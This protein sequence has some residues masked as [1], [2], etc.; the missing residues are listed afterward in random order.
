VAIDEGW[1]PAYAKAAGTDGPVT[2]LTF[3]A[4]GADLAALASM[5]PPF[6][7]PVWA[8]TV[9]GMALDDADWSEVEELITDSYRAVA[10]RRLASRVE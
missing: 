8:E 6:F 9:V 5:G 1:P 3:H 2:V 7:K 10:P 4:T